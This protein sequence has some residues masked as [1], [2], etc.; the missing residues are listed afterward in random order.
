MFLDPWIK[1]VQVFGFIKHFVISGSSSKTVGNLEGFFCVVAM[2]NKFCVR[3]CSNEVCWE[4]MLLV[5]SDGDVVM[6]KWMVHLTVVDEI[7][8]ASSRAKLVTVLPHS[9]LSED[10]TETV[11]QLNWILSCS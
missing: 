6:R 5:I 8:P 1:W 4:Q 7:Y 2:L 9:L 10:V 11:F 3:P